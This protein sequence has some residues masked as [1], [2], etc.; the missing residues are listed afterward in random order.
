MSSI[1]TRDKYI[2]LYDEHLFFASYFVDQ[3]TNI[4]QGSFKITIDI[5][6]DLRTLTPA[7]VLKYQ[8]II[9]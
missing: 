2:I 6:V 1:P 9:K 5:L 3:K 4:E 7:I 8:E